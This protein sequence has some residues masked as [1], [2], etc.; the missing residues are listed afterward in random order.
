MKSSLA[1][2]DFG[3]SIASPVAAAGLVNASKRFG[4]TIAL[5]HASFD[6]LPGEV[7]ALLG[8]NGAGKSTCVKLLAGVYR[9]DEGAVT[10]GGDPVE[11]WSP[12]EAQRRGIAVMHQHPGLFGDLTVFE[13]IFVGH[14][15]QRAL[16]R[17]DY[18]RM[19]EEARA[20]L[21][22]VGL[23]CSPEDTLKELRTSEQQLVEIAR[24]LSVNA[25]VLI[26][27]EPTAA[28]SQRE[29]ERLFAVVADLKAR[30]V[31]MM[32]VGHRM[33]EIYRIADRI[34]VLRDGHLIGVRQAAELDRDQAVQ[35]MIGRPLKAIYPQWESKPGQEV[36][37][38]SG[39]SREGAFED[40]S[41]NVRAGEIVGLGGLVGSGRTEIARVLFGIDQPTAG[42][43]EMEG[44]AV[45]FAD[46]PAAMAAGIAYVS[47]DR[48]GQ[49]L[50]MDFPI[51]DNASLPVIEKATM[52]G[53]V[54]R[55]QELA[56]VEPHLK[57][58]KLKFRSFDQPVKTL[59]GGNQ[60][61]V[62]LSKWLAT[63][64]RLLI[65]DEPTQGIDVESKS[66]VHT[67]IAELAQQ[68]LAIILISSELPELV[69]MCDRIVVLREGRMAGAFTRE[70][71]D[72]EKVIRAATDA[73]GV[74]AD[75]QP[76]LASRDDATKADEAKTGWLK[77]LLRRREVG[78]VGA[79]AA[80][81][82]PVMF[83][84]P[85]MVSPENLT[86]IAM[87]AALLMIVA[88]AQMLVL[89]TRNIDL[90]VASV[91]GLSAYGAASFMHAHPDSSVLLGVGVA[92]VVGLACGALNGLVVTLGRVPA[93]V[94]T[95]GTLSVFR[96]LN[97]LWAGG[98]Q[99]SADQ[100]PQAWLDMTSARIAGIPAVILIALACLVV[101]GLILRHWPVGRELY[102]I[103]SNP[104]GA[105]LIGIRR[106]AL[107][108]GAFMLAGLLAGFDGALWA[109]RYATIDARVALGFELT[110]IASVVVGGV[111]IRG[112]A[113]TVLGVAL[114]ALTLLVI[115][116]GLTL[117]RVDPL[118]LQG[119]YGLVILLAIGVD[120]IIGRRTHQGRRAR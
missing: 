46:P 72:Q 82:L 101:I 34:A 29:V 97:S 31:A 84:N 47:E 83:L 108:L 73:G 61:K 11:H 12:L 42:R 76:A 4:G 1:D 100:V 50:V 24:A 111:A 39:V 62:V 28:L 57:R 8:E 116:N 81:V 15:P 27:D 52:A 112:G 3:A 44:K 68:G 79:M 85:R 107:V 5:S 2:E 113:G 89:L 56:L 60:Q 103:G 110:V 96:G 9:P 33:E 78:L 94:V 74:I 98:R 59:S 10:I 30:Q 14:M 70:E 63:Q 105:A 87:D 118:W 75:K 36:L 104:D 77:A 17:I 20:L 53:L 38:V 117:V 45:A 106:T 65:L 41:F 115:Q 86:A 64:P 35:M 49:S 7:L 25:K 66:E 99:I 119:V 13:N 40:V 88:V 69:S 6:L 90:S 43:I 19:R 102:A 37:S 109:S 54:M 95:L 71:A 22:V 93:I 18:E 55:R 51:L 114:G 80:V 58:L 26:M 92:C 23:Q 32:F 67:M 120:T 91:I 48:L 21:D 16:G